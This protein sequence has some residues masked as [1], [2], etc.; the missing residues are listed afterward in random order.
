M[1]NTIFIIISTILLGI[2]AF[3]VFLL[4]FGFWIGRFHNKPDSPIKD[5]CHDKKEK[6]EKKIEKDC[7]SKNQKY[8]CN[9]RYEPEDEYYDYNTEKRYPGFKDLDD[10][11]KNY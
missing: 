2:I 9:R 4:F 8:F 11:N 3:L 7:P 1:I 5:E 10:L 6:C